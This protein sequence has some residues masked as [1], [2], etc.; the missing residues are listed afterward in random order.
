MKGF[1]SLTF[2]LLLFSFGQSRADVKPYALLRADVIRESAG[3]LDAD[4]DSGF[5]STG[6]QSRWVG[7]IND[8]TSA[9]SFRRT[10]L[11]VKAAESFSGMDLSGKLEVDFMGEVSQ[12]NAL[13]AETRVRYGYVDMMEKTCGTHWI[14]GQTNDIVAPLNPTTL[15]EGQSKRAGN[16]GYRRPQIQMMKEFFD[17]V[18]VQLS[19][20]KPW[21]GRETSNQFDYAGH[22]GVSTKNHMPIQVDLGIGHLM[23]KD[24]RQTY[25]EGG[26]SQYQNNLVQITALDGQIAGHGLTLKGEWYKGTDALDYQGVAGYDARHLTSQK[27]TGWW[28]DLTF[29]R[30][31]YAFTVGYSRAAID[32]PDVNYRANYEGKWIDRNN[33]RWANFTYEVEKDLNIGFEYSILKTTW[34]VDDRDKP[35]LTGTGASP[36]FDSERFNLAL[37]YAL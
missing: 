17:M 22:F 30:A 2:T 24:R 14:F 16:V 37:T 12:G 28:S 11:G 13:A 15:N 32:S 9:V 20:S 21:S 10:K 1:I 6:D 29:Q 5:S 27:E 34:S 35:Y 25:F 4:P 23:G 8:S 26:N 31:A 33:R 18:S 36:S 7:S 19:A 3:Q